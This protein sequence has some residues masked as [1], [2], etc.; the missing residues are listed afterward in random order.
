MNRGM[1]FWASNVALIATAMSFAI[2]GD[3]MESLKVKYVEPYVASHDSAEAAAS[4]PAIVNRIL[5]ISE[6]TDPINQNLGI[7]AGIA[8]LSFGLTILFGGPLVDLLGMGNLLRVAAACHIGGT[9]LT[10]FAPSFWMV[11][12]A[13]FIIGAGNGLVEAVCN[14]LIATL[15]PEEKAHK[16]TLFHA[17]FPGGIVIG[18]VLAYVFSLIGLNWQVK[19]SLI[20]IPAVIYTFMILGQKFPPTE[21]VASG[22]SFGDMF[23]EAARRPLF[24]ILFVIMWLTA[25]T[26][27]GTGQWISNIFNNVMKREEGILALVWGSVLMY[28]MRQFFSKPVHKISPIALMAITAP[29]AALGLFLFKFA[30]SPVMFFVAATLVYVGVCFWWPTMLGITSERCPKSGALGLAII[31]GVG[32]FATSLAGPTIGRII[33]HYGKEAG[34]ATALQLWAI[35]PVVITVVFALIYF[36]DKAKGGY[37]RERLETKASAE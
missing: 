20:L 16:L 7:I 36:S 6:D 34:P 5:G 33:D 12:F 8:F 32:S 25:A 2:R 31:G 24:W 11:V 26:E 4:R 22:Y 13:T 21:R 10:I 27:L 17:W 35:L 3:I 37:Q 15:Y 18:G 9:L 23:K 28:I 30:S 1:L 14:P 29:I 19:M